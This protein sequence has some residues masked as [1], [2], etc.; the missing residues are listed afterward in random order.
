MLSPLATP[1]D[2]SPLNTLLEDLAAAAIA[3]ILAAGNQTQDQVRVVR[4]TNLTSL[5]LEHLG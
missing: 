3:T 2:S 1:G 5:S 4:L